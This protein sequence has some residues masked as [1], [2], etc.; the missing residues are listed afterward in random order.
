MIASENESVSL[1]ITVDSLQPQSSLPME[2][3]KQEYWVWLPFPSP[4][5]LPLPGIEPRSPEL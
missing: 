5:D 1:S 2:F 4:V 3:S